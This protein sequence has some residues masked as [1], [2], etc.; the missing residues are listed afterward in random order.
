MYTIEK[1][2]TKNISMTCKGQGYLVNL[3]RRFLRISTLGAYMGNNTQA[4]KKSHGFF[5]ERFIKTFRGLFLPISHGLVR[6]GFTPNMVTFISLVLG[7]LTGVFLGL[8]MIYVGLATGVIM[9]FSDLIDGQMAKEFGG[10]T[11]FGGVLDSTIDRFNE[12][13]IFA[14]FAV[15]YYFLGRP[16]WMIFCAFA[17]LGSIMISYV[18]ARAESAGFD[19]KV[20]FLQ[21]PERLAVMGVFMLFGSIGIDVILVFMAFATQV[22]VINRLLHVYRQGQRT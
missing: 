7:M 20:G 18:R 22:T 15:R 3:D 16:E 11:K 13:F 1:E 19:C 21:R 2:N 12:F 5:T 6:V 17:F 4:E 10:A 9:G 8:D 14:G